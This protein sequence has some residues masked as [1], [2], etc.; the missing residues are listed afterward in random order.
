MSIFTCMRYTTAHRLQSSIEWQIIIARPSSW[1][2]NIHG[3]SPMILNIDTKQFQE[4][5]DY[6]EI[7]NNPWR[8][9]MDKVSADPDNYIEIVR[10][11]FGLNFNS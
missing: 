5:G 2:I 11:H 9:D 6:F 7:E 1:Q 3:Y 10:P 4:N 8:S